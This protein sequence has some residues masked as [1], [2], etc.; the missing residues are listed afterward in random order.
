M[1]RN[2][3]RGLNRGFS[4]NNKVHI[5]KKEDLFRPLKM[6]RDFKTHKIN[7]YGFTCDRRSH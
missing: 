6:T 7:F 5:T 1:V 4:R 2:R 3:G